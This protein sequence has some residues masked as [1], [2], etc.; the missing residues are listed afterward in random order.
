MGSGFT[1]LSAG[2]LLSLLRKFLKLC[3]LLGG[4]GFSFLKPLVPIGFGYA[5]DADAEAD[6]LL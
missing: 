4:G 6:V 2:L 3:K 5:A 1:G